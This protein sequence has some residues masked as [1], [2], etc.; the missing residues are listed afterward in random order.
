MAVAA[1]RHNDAGTV[2]LAEGHLDD[3]EA[4]FRLALEYH[5]H[6]AEAHLN[7]ALVLLARGRLDEA[8][9]HLGTAVELDEDYAEAHGNLGV[10]Y[11][12]TGNAG[13]AERSFV[14]ALAIDPGLREPRL[15][16]AELWVAQE[17]FREARAQLLRLV[18][19]APEDLGAHAW[20]AYCD[21]RLGRDADALDRA[22][23]VL[24]RDPTQP[25][26]HLV[27]AQD[28]LTRGDWEATRAHAELALEHPPTRE[29]A[30][31]TLAAMALVTHDLPTASTLTNALLAQNPSSRV[32][33]WLA[34]EVARQSAPQPVAAPGA[35]AR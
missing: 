22:D 27:F 31:A 28:A 21:L 30:L 29:A 7:L 23:K 34:D 15:N 3:A 13:Q 26:A 33:H 14:A 17:R 10:Y 8:G 20:L 32:G 4:R 1:Q 19:V 5:P 9:A 24:T 16:L 35:P 6:F 11:L 25:V 2:L 18:Q 12:L